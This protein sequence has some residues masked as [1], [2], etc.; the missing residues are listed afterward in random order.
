MKVSTERLPGSQVRLEIEVEP[1]RLERSLDQ[2]YRR[3][4]QR[5]RVPGFRPGKA[6]RVMVERY[7]GRETLLQE[8]LDR[9]VPEVYNEALEEH[10]IDAVDRP[11]LQVSS[12]EPVTVTATVPV[13]PTVELGEYRAL[14]LEHEPVAVEDSALEEALDQLRHRYATLEPLERPAQAGDIV[15]AEVQ[16]TVGGRTLVR[17]KDGRFPLRAAPDLPGLVEGITGMGKG[18]SGQF[19]GRFPEDYPDPELAGKEVAYTVALRELKEERLP[20]LD[21]DFARGVGEGFADLAALEE[22]IRA[23]LKAAAEKQERDRYE[24]RIVDRILAGA[25]LEYPAVLVEREVE[26]LLREHSGLSADPAERQRQLRMTAKSEDELRT[27]LT[28]A[29]EDRVRRSLVLRKVAELEGIEVTP[30]EVDAEVERLAA[31]TGD[32]AERMRQLFGSRDGRQAVERTLL[33]RKTFDR[34]VATAE[35]RQ[36]S[37]P[38]DVSPAEAGQSEN[39]AALATAAPGESNE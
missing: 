2:A 13:R 11:E 3:L 19:G 25:S 12:L 21:D 28:P 18:E 20:A 14:R 32:R 31:A 26:H 16:A 37:E 5:T 22:R 34:L 33:A 38:A 6:P 29:A 10:G 8:A 39:G 30:A 1:D 23:D 36:V 4:V 17:E 9:L 35:G 24:D 7:L 27:E 15:W